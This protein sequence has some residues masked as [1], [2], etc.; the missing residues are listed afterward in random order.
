[1]IIFLQANTAKSAKSETARDKAQAAAAKA[2]KDVRA[3]TSARSSDT[4]MT[5][6]STVL[7]GGGAACQCYVTT[8]GSTVFHLL[9][10]EQAV[11][12]S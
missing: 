3:I 8:S 12:T 9:Q 4:D 5:D 1:M 10:T 11:Q 2:M 7:Q 6:C